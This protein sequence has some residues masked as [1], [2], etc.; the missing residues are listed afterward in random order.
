MYMYRLGSVVAVADGVLL[1]VP[2]AAQSHLL[3]AMACLLMRKG[4]KIVFLPDCKALVREPVDYF[5][6][7]LLLTFATQPA[8]QT[9]VA[10]LSTVDEVIRFCKSQVD[11]TYIIDQFNAVEQ[12]MKKD[13][14]DTLQAKSLAHR[15][16]DRATFDRATLKAASANNVTARVVHDKQLN[17]NLQTLFGGMTKV[18]RSRGTCALRVQCVC[19]AR[20]LRAPFT[21]NAYHLCCDCCS[22]RRWSRGAAT[23]TSYRPQRPRLR[24]LPLLAPPPL[25]RMALLLRLCLRRPIW[26][27]PT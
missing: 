25:P 18:R 22:R 19:K 17:I 8:V 13:D 1:L 9:Q 7:A 12:D 3:A 24:L 27:L 21:L 5:R 11:L 15:L 23:S 20:V 4:R 10:R 6:A 2:S 16:I 26:C 14:S